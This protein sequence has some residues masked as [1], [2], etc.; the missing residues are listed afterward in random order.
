VTKSRANWAQSLRALRKPYDGKTFV[1]QDDRNID[2]A[3]YG[4]YSLINTDQGVRGYLHVVNDICY[5]RASRLRL[6]RWLPE[7]DIPPD[8]VTGAEKALVTLPK[9]HF[10]SFVESISAGLS[11][12]D[13]RTSSAP[14]LE[15]VLRRQK[16]VFRGS[17]GYKEI[18]M[19]LLECLSRGNTEVAEVA[20]TLLNARNE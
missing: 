16:L 4:P 15:E 6:N 8:P 12:F 9:Q 17:G 13:W 18:R 1:S 11:D 10:A 19:Q 2:P 5:Q 20:N 7:T 3:F 14:G